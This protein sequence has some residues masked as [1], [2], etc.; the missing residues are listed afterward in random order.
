MINRRYNFVHI[1]ITSLKFKNRG[2]N[3][4]YHP[5]C[6]GYVC[7]CGGGALKDDK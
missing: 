7:V 2:Q 1:G 5:V 4:F 6:I 3:S